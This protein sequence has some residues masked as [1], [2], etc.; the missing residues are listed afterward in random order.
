MPRQDGPFAILEAYL[1]SSEYVLDLPKL[2]NI[3]NKFHASLLTPH[4]QNDDILFLS[5]WLEMPGPVVTEDG[6]EEHFIDCILDEHCH[7]HSVQYLVC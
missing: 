2:M 1:K 7:G 5:Q 4:V 3:L 6:Q